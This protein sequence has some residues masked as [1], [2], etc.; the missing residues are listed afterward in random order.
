[1]GNSP[2]YPLRSASKQEHVPP[3]L[4][5]MRRTQVIR[6][7]TSWTTPDGAD[8]RKGRVGAHRTADA[9]RHDGL[10]ELMWVFAGSSQLVNSTNPLQA[11]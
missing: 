5:W 11:T 4:R 8:T 9:K 6:L 1:M 10:M 7:R 2:S 3:T